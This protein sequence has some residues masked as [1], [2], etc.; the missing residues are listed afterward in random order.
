MLQWN[1]L[2]ITP[3]RKHLVIDVQ[4][5]PLPYYE[6]VYIDALIID[7]QKTF[8]ETGPSNKPLMTIP[9]GEEAKHVREFIDIDTLADNL[10]F[11]YAVAS[12]EPT[13][14]TPCGMSDPYILGLAYDKYPMYTRGMSLIQEA[15]G[16]DP[17]NDFINYILQQ[18]AFDISLATGNY[19]QAIEYWNRFFDQKKQS[20]RNKCGCHGRFV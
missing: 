11:I 15:N 7:T 18:K 20:V 6:N 13:E 12:G 8:L 3:D 14:D 10:F 16:C 19:T 5:Q 2:R 17:A 1:E 9:C 4:V